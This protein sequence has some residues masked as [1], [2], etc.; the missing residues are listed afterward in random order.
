MMPPIAPAVARETS[1]GVCHGSGLWRPMTGLS[2]E[3][4]IS[5]FPAM[6]HL[7]I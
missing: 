3:P 1:F 6:S 5:S 2:I 7:R 4:G